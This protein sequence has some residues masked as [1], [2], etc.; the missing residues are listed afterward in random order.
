MNRLVFDIETVGIPLE[1]FDEG[2]QE[3]LLR[4]A[5]T[6]EEREQA[7]RNLNLS[8]LTSRVACIGM[9]NI[10]AQKGRTYYLADAVGSEAAEGTDFVAF[11]DETELLRSFWELIGTRDRGHWKYEKYVT[12]NGRSFDCPFLMLRSAVLGLRPSRNLMDGTRYNLRDHVDLMEELTF[13]SGT[14][15]SGA[16]RRFNLDFYCK[17]FGITSPKEEG[18]TGRDVNDYFA[19]QRYREIAEYCMRDVRAT[20]DLYRRWESLLSFSRT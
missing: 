19:A 12:F 17:A 15:G 4:G 5:T 2:R 13:Y 8:P 14:W 6:D 10:D 16:T 7:L 20:A 11:T 9:V 3:Y 18:M 1:T